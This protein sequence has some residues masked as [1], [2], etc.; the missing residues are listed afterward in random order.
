MD[1]TSIIYNFALLTLLGLLVAFNPLLIV[2]DFLL[3]LKSKRPIFNT[4]ILLA[5]FATSLIIL[6]LVANLL[7][8]ADSQISLKNVMNQ[9]DIPSIVDLSAGFILLLYG[10]R[11]YKSTTLESDALKR[12]EI[13]IPESPKGIYVFALLKTS[14]SI[15]NI[16]AVV[17]LARQAIVSN[18]SIALGF[19]SL[20]FLLIIGIMPLLYIMYLHWFKKESLNTI[21]KRLNSLISRGTTNLLAYGLILIGLLFFIK[22][23]VGIL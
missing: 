7:L 23:L 20:V 19:L 13:K 6:F 11:K 4:V 12:T 10:F 22:G 2:V 16:F 3:V 15:T 18:W 21:D 17:I 5:G 14:L 9:R 1:L 8:S